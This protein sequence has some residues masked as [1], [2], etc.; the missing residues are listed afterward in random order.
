MLLEEPT[1]CVITVQDGLNKYVIMEELAG[2]PPKS[3]FMPQRSVAIL[4][5]K[6]DSLYNFDA[7]LTVSEAETLREDPRILAVRVGSKEENGLILVSEVLDPLRTYSR[8]STLDNTHYNWCLANSS[9]P[10]D[11]FSPTTTT[12]TYRFPYTLDGTGIDIVIQ[13]SGIEPNHPEWISWSTGQTRLR[14]INWPEAAGLSSI[15]TQSP[16]F[17]RDTHGHGTH[18]AGIAAGRLY[19]WAKNAD[20]YAMKMIE[21]STDVSFGVSAS[22]NL[23]RHWHQRKG[24]G[25]PTIVNMSWGYSSGYTNITGGQWRGTNWT[26]TA[27]R[28]D[29]GMVQGRSIG[30]VWQH[31]IRTASVDSDIRACL[32]AGIILVAAIGNHSHYCARPSDIDFNNYFTSST[33]GTQYYHQGPTPAGETGVIT[34]GNVSNAYVSGQEAKLLSSGT[35]PRSDIFAPGSNIMSAIPNGSSI[36]S[37]V[38]SVPYPT[39]SSFRCTKLTGSSMAAPQVAGML[40]TFLQLRP[41]MTQEELVQMMVNDSF[42]NRLTDPTTGVPAT[43]YQNFRALNGAPNR[44]LRTIFNRS[45]PLTITGNGQVS[46]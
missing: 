33:L 15:Y 41:M 13:D 5:E 42:S 45:S 32:A 25:R 20:I 17:Y 11:L 23:I 37:S 30:G 8:N 16:L 29:Y 19:G 14:Q 3:S 7:A 38:G 28:G 26:G 31:P 1:R 10:V 24:T 36:G 4:N 9:S 12:A 22:F 2:P 43:D 39:N 44:Y 18:C 27:M 46:Y 6:T 34:V 21:D 40:A 35:G